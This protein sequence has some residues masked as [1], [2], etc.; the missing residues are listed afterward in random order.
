MGGLL[1][2]MVFLVIGVGVIE[3]ASADNKP[4]ITIT[5]PNGGEVLEKG[6]T[7]T[8]TWTQLNV[9][10]LSIDLSIGSTL[11]D[12]VSNYDCDITATSGSYDFTVSDYNHEGDN[13]KINITAYNVG[14]GQAI[15]ES[16]DYFSIKE[17]KTIQVIS[18]NG[19]EQWGKEKIRDIEWIS[20][21]IDK[22]KIFLLWNEE[23]DSPS[24]QEIVSLNSN[25]GIYKWIIP[26]TL[27]LKSNYRI[28]VSDGDKTMVTESGKDYDLSNDYFSVMEREDITNVKIT[29]I[30]KNRYD[31]AAQI[32]WTSPY[33]ITLNR[34]YR[35]TKKG[36]L[37]EVLHLEQ[38]SSCAFPNNASYIDNTVQLG[39]DYYYTIRLVEVNGESGNTDQYHYKKDGLTNI[40][41]PNGGETLGIGKSYY[42]KW[43]S[44]G[45]AGKVYISLMENYNNMLIKNKTLFSNIENDGS[46]LWT[47]D[48]TIKIGNRYKI[49]ITNQDSVFYDYND[50]D[51]YFSIVESSTPSDST[52]CLPDNTLIKLPG[53]PKIYVI[54]NCQRYWIKTAEE[55]RQ[56]GYKWEDVQESSSDVVSSLPEVESEEIKEGAIIRAKDGV[57]IYI[58]KYIGN[59]KFIR[60]IL[61][62]SVFNSYGHLKWENVIEVEKETIDSFVISNLVRNAETGKIYR[63]TANGDNGTRRHFQSI[64]VMQRLGYDLD[65]VYEINGTDENSYEQGEDLE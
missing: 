43:N 63:L 52:N 45:N 38:F 3:K 11:Y 40:I 21:G 44:T 57:D 17:P 35:S 30:S 19:G 65:A 46:V 10:K 49:R 56:R 64:S 16:D 14:I 12:I 34:I 4:S 59:K 1:L 6:K 33:A 54:K 2:T 31:E 9:N 55:F 25:P 24:S 58:V 36:E 62:P 5:S 18:P 28:Q 13:Y 41:F 32:T 29:G 50:S 37:G 61:N 53:S 48:S 26:S 27:S 23:D 47:P 39:I 60:L 15:D 42:I 20:T 8:I 51:D 22:V 7:Y